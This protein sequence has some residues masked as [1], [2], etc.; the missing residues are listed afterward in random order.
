MATYYWVGGDGTWD[1]S[2][3]A[4]WS[5]TSGG[6]GGAG[7]PTSAD[8][9][10]VN[11][12]SGSDATTLTISG[13]VSCKSFVYTGYLQVTGVSSATVNCYGN[14]QFNAT[15]PTGDVPTTTFNVIGTGS[16]NIISVPTLYVVTLKYSGSSVTYNFLS[17][18]TCSLSVT[19]EEYAVADL[20]S[21]TITAPRCYAYGSM[22]DGGVTI[23]DGS[24]R[25]FQNAASGTYTGLTVTVANSSVAA[26][27]YSEGSTGSTDR[28]IGL[29]LDCALSTTHLRTTQS[30]IRINDLSV[31]S[32]SSADASQ[33]VVV[34]G[35]IAVSSTF[36]LEGA[37]LELAKPSN[38]ATAQTRSIDWGTSTEL[39]Y[40]NVSVASVVVGATG[41]ANDDV[42]WSG[43]LTAKY[44]VLLGVNYLQTAT[45][46]I[47]DKFVVSNTM[48]AA[49]ATINAD[50]TSQTY[51]ELGSYTYGTINVVSSTTSMTGSPTIGTLNVSTSLGE[52]YK[53]LYMYVTNATI[54]G[55]FLLSGA[56][57]SDVVG[58]YGAGAGLTTI[59][60]S[61]GSVNAQNSYI[62][63]IAA[64][65]GATFYAL[66][67]N[68]NFN[69]GG[70][71]GWIFS[72]SGFLM[73]F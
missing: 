12:S 69:G 43:S 50:G 31:T 71:T 2:S 67:K 18:V 61:S 24:T 45:L 7:V 54:T 70:N 26:F 17:N 1:S 25:I 55:D 56:S 58:I 37:T 39:L 20:N 3:S 8:D 9:V 68:G 53:T 38:V 63:N 30:S 62:Q 42:Y 15:T 34:Y 5:L 52:G 11:T 22:T 44:A 73:F 65:G 66:L 41:S 64:T 33:T 51:L 57:A 49:S 23:S 4:N 27:V 40:G 72:V 28:A 14:L 13:T 29:V 10:R 16:V 48:S 21:Y 46:T 59:T 19:L 6:S 36:S 47:A 35:D 60:K 32:A